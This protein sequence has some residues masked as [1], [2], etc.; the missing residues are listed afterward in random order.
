[1]FTNQPST[2]NK[3]VINV[4]MVQI[5]CSISQLRLNISKNP[6]VMRCGI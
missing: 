6:S 3:A 2:E 5:H 1:M 4:K